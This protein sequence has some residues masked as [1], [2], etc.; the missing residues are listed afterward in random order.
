MILAVFRESMGLT[1][2][3]CAVQLGLSRSS[4][5]WLSDIENGIRPA[6]VRLALK[7]ESWSEG[8]VSAASVCPGLGDHVAPAVAPSSLAPPAAAGAENPDANVSGTEAGT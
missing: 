6:S 1:L 2:E 3:Q 8:K 7:I 5:S 4:K